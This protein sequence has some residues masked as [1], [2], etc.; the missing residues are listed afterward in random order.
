MK[1]LWLQ[2]GGCGGC[3]LSWLGAEGSALFST[4]ADENIEILWHPSLS[5]ESCGEARDLI[6]ACADGS[7]SF[8]IL[9]LEGSVLRGPYGSGGYHRHAGSGHTACGV[10]AWTS[11]TVPMAPS[12][13]HS[14]NWRIDSVA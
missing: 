11:R 13:T 8:D 3:T 2:S 6:A 1:I 9:A 14:Q 10:Q 12:H 5:Q 7:L 4:L